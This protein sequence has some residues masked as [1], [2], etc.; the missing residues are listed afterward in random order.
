MSSPQSS[1]THLS[2][3][4]L[5]KSG[6]EKHALARPFGCGAKVAVDLAPREEAKAIP[7][8]WDSTG[9]GQ[10]VG[11]SPSMVLVGAE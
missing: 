6:Q 1:K 4:L 10:A 11:P 5:G 2:P 9:W 8:V 7:E 3:R